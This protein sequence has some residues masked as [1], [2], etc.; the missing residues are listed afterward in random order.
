VVASY[1]QCRK[2]NA[3]RVMATIFPIR[4]ALMYDI[5]DISQV[6]WDELVFELKIRGIKDKLSQMVLHPEI[7]NTEGKVFLN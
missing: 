4:N 6:T 7:I 2:T 1:D 5:A 3:N